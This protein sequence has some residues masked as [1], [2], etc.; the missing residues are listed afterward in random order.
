MLSHIDP[1]TTEI[2]AATGVL[3]YVGALLLWL[4]FSEV[5]D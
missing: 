3:V 1:A 5:E 2:V 4:L